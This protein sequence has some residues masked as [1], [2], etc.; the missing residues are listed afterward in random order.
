MRNYRRRGVERRLGKGCRP[1]S[2]K[3][4]ALQ[5]CLVSW[6][7]SLPSIEEETRLRKLPWRSEEIRKRLNR[8]KR[9]EPV[10]A[11]TIT[12]PMTSSSSSSS[13][14]SPSSSSSSSSFVAKARTCLDGRHI[15]IEKL[16]SSCKN[17][18]GRV[19]GIRVDRLPKDGHH[20][21][22]TAASASAD[23]FCFLLYFHVCSFKHKDGEFTFTSS[24][25]TFLVAK[26]VTP[27]LLWGRAVFNFNKLNTLCNAPN[28]KTLG[29][30]RFCA[31][32]LDFDEKQILNGKFTRNR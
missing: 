26:S 4:T 29:L 22:R 24:I 3:I 5:P 14:S 23:I 20:R 6:N 28:K 31:L 7:R 2:L 32:I 30:V 27:P 15:F 16:C 19:S 9:H 11:T 13:S 25:D 18:F 12:F 8:A 17:E 10:P 21:H 1:R